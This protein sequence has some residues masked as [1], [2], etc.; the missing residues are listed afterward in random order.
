MC[1]TAATAGIRGT[2]G[3]GQISPVLEAG[4]GTVAN[5]GFGAAIGSKGHAR[6]PHKSYRARC[7]HRAKDAAAEVSEGIDVTINTEVVGIS[8]YIY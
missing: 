3:C 7:S 8:P 4:V 2:V 1:V 5:A 6:W